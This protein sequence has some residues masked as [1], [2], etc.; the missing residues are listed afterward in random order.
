MLKSALNMLCGALICAAVSAAFAVGTP[1][2]SGNG[3]ALQDGQWLL[4]LA[5]GQNYSFQ[6]GITALGTTQATAQ[7][8][9]AAVYLQEVDTTASGTGVNL[10][11]CQAGTQVVLYNNGASTLTIYPTVPNNPG[12]GA[13]DTINNG[14][15]LSG[16]LASHTQIAF[17]CIKTGV[18]SAS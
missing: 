1:P 14:T 4:G 9:A 15:T 5:N 10:P 8:L 3:F 16:G 11:S 18:W 2:L 17:A 12:T 7:Q 13:Q 6:S